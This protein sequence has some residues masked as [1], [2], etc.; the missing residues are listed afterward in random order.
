MMPS[1][2]DSASRRRAI[3]LGADDFIAKPIDP[4][5]LETR[6]KSLLRISL[7]QQSLNNLNSELERK[8]QQRTEHLERAL[9]HVEEAWEQNKLAYRETVMRL[10]LAAEFKDRCT[11]THL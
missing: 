4:T 8:V 10:G 11:A 3:D 2:S 7:Y 5:E 1:W 6:V 9:K